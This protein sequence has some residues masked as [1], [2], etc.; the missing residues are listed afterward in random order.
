MNLRRPIIAL[1]LAIQAAHG[2]VLVNLD[3][4][5]L[6]AGA[7]TTWS[8]SGTLGGSFTRQIDTP[9]VTTVA[10]VKAVTLDGANDWYVGPTAPASVTGNGVRTVEVW[11]YNPA[12]ADEETMVA[13]GR[14]GGGDGTN[15]SFG[16]GSNATYGAVAH[17]G[18]PDVGWG[19]VP[20]AASW[21]Y[22]VY[23]FDGSVTRMYSDG[24]LRN[25]ES[26]ALNTW[27]VST[28]GA[29][30]PFVIGT[31][32]SADGTRT[33]GTY[34]GSMSIAKVRVRNE[35]LELPAIETAYISEGQP[36]GKGQ[37]LLKAFA[38]SATGAVPAGTPVQL[39]WNVVGATSVS[40]SNAPAI[41]GASGTVIVF[42][43]ATTTYTFTATNAAGITTQ[44]A[45]VTVG[46]FTP[47]AM[48]HRYSFNEASGTSVL[49]SV[50]TAHG[51]ILGAGW[52]RA[53]GSV[54]LPGGASG[55]APYVDLPNSLVSTLSNCT[56]EGWV[57]VTGNQAWSRI[58]DFGTGT[59]G[60]ITA[61]GSNATGT[62]YLFLSAQVGG[63]SNTQRAAL[64]ANNQGENFSDGAF[65]TVFGVETHFAVS[66]NATGNA[67]SPQIQYYRDG[68][69]VA[70][71]NTSYTLSQISDVNNWLGRSNYTADAN[72]QGA[73]NEFRIWNGAFNANDV[74]QSRNLGPSSAPVGPYI[75][76]FFA[77]PSTIYDGESTTLYWGVTNQQNPFSATITP[78][79]GSVSGTSGSTVVIPAGLGDVTYTFSG[80]NPLGTRTAQAVVTVL[81]GAP[82]AASLSANTFQE[83]AKA[84]TLTATDPNTPVGSL[85]YSYGQP[86]HGT[87]TGVAP[88]VTYTPTPGY[89]G[90]DSFTYTASDSTHTSN[91]ATVSI[92]VLSG[93][94]IANSAS[95]STAQNVA[96][97]ITLVAT[98]P[99]TPLGGLTYAY[100]QPANGTVTGSGPSVTYTPSSGFFGT[101]S[102]SFTAGDGTHVSTAATITITV[103]PPPTA[104]TFITPSES[105]ILTDI[106][107]GSFFARLQ[108]TDPNPGDTHTFSL[109]AGTGDTHNAFF[110]VVGNQ[111]ISSHSFAGDAGQTISIR[112]RATDNTG[113]TFDRVITFPVQAAAPHVK[114]NEIHYNPARNTLLSEFIELYNPTG[115]AVDMSGWRFNSGVNY[116][117]PPGTTIAAGGYLV[118][119]KDPA[120]I[121]SLYGVTA[122]GPWEG[123]LDSQGEEIILRDTFGNKIDGVDYGITSPWPTASNG[124]GPSLELVHPALDNDM[125]G[126]WRAS[127]RAPVSV[128]YVTA[129]S[130][131]WRYRKGTSEASSPVTAWRG[132]AF[133]EDGTW[134]TGTAPIGVFKQNNNTSLAT[135]AETGVT[136]GT[137]LTDMAAYSG[138]FTTSYRSVFFR[139]TFTA[140]SDIPKQLLLR[141][142]HN[143]AA[144]IWINSVEVARF[145][146][147]EGSPASPAFNSSAYY[148]RGNDPWSEK[149]IL[150]TDTLLHS[151]TNTIAIMGF[152]KPPQLRSEQEDVGA[153][154]LFD[155]CIDASLTNVPDT[156]GTPGA[157]NSVF[158]TNCPPAVRNITQVPKQLVS[159]APVTITAKVSDPQGVGSVTLSYQ[160]CTAGN[161]IPATLPLSIAALQADPNQPL[162]ANPAFENTAN[163]TTISM[164]DNG[165]VAGDVAGDGVFTAIIPAQPHRALVRYR[166]NATDLASQAV[167]L[168]AVG[169][170]RLNFAA[171]V[172]DGVPAYGAFTPATLNTL[173]AYHWITRS[174][175]FSSLL[176]YNGAEQIPNSN[177]L[178]QLL[179]RRYEN[180]EGTLV[181]GDQVID[182]ARIRLRG[183]NSRYAGVSGVSNIGKRHFRLNFPKGTPLQAEDNYGNKY[184][185][186]WEE[187]LFNKMF[188]NKGYHDF[189]LPYAV[190]GKMWDLTGVPTPGNHWVHFRVVQNANESDPT[191]GD[192]WGMYQALETPEGKNFLAARNLPNGNFYK[193][194]D[195]VQNGEM[196]DR[197]QAATSVDFAEDFDNIR[198]NIHQGTTQADME[199]FINM[200]AYYR[201][202]A[203]QEAIRH[204]D[205]FVE[206]TGRHRVKN[207][208]WWFEPQV[209]NPLGRC[210]FMPYDWDA[211][212]GPSWNSGYEMV[213]NA[214]Y[215]LYPITDS[216]TWTGVIQNRAAM[217]I[218]RRNAIRE[219][220]DLLVY[221]D[222]TGR[223]PVD[224]IIDD[225]YARIAAFW[226]ADRQR[227][228]ATGAQAD[229]PS[230]PPYKVAD[231]KSFLFTGWTDPVNADPAVGAGGRAAYLD[232]ISDGFDAGQLP[233]KPTIT[234]ASAL[235]HPVDGLAFTSSAFSDPQGAGTFAAMQWRVGEITD[236]LAPE[237][238]PAA[239][240]V[241]EIT[242]VWT[243]GELPTFNASVTIPGSALR[244]GH[245][246]RARVRH[247]DNTGRWSHWSNPVAFTCTSSNY[248]QVLKDNLVVSEFMY[249][250]DDPDLAEATAGYLAG[251]FEWIELRNVSTSLTLDLSN[252]RFTKGVDFDFQ[253][254]AITSLAPGASALVVKDAA[255]FSMRYGAGHPIAGEWDI[256]DNL[257][258]SGEQL[259]LSL[260]AGDA[261]HDFDYKPIAPWPTQANLGG[262][263]LVLRSP[264]TRPNHN[265]GG[266]WRASSR[267]DGTPGL[268]GTVFSE[269]AS[270]NLVAGETTDSDGDGIGNQLE[271]GLG[272]NPNTN[273]R[274][275]LPTASIQTLVVSGTPGNY[276]TLTFRR[277]PAAEDLTYSAE[278]SSDLSSP[279]NWAASGVF[280]SSTSNPDGSVS[281][282][283]RAATPLTPGQRQFGRVKMVKP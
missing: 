186:K 272:A 178:N 73:F 257:S 183:G 229:H 154:N 225:A 239:P 83:T 132:E 276:L 50:G 99:D 173:P 5:A 254:S 192:F 37:P 43:S 28:G 179:A 237:Y 11:A 113:R 137:Q 283:W 136:L 71:L 227:W 67:G 13:W 53:G 107:S 6:P 268:A 220:R 162:P 221:R 169:D 94:P 1:A 17:W 36:F 160:I 125:G 280:V 101:D 146:F 174:S 15:V 200:P 4:T 172:Y 64:K 62:G 135:L 247:K 23:V 8:N 56:V 35:A 157:Q 250:P 40:I 260:G 3:A 150:N 198:Y 80:T 245:T 25:T 49:D 109:V 118:I 47:P 182:H 55:T 119:A 111:L 207:L 140:T 218:Q 24:V 31:Q 138:G 249:R 86:A 271:Y 195:W 123:G 104:P 158:S 114:I 33:S 213:V 230:G 223:G 262:Y 256:E 126:H 246:Y 22:L 222:G 18:T 20:T 16:F 51:T 69:L 176:A 19:T 167:R 32:N 144:V 139:R 224:D 52:N 232:T 147:P 265:V 81:S 130:T 91:T 164:V 217:Q 184:P 42:P 45:T 128:N 68:A 66:Y 212:F 34:G 100:S 216:P 251:D 210:L 84:I 76:S 143:D 205:L 87:V 266:N 274:A 253:G 70:T 279:F 156:L 79:P 208:I 242:E 236:P 124:D 159:T 282:T 281:E 61:P 275:Q 30:L 240:R 75:N 206:P 142:M 2:E 127:T 57:T 211:S 273:S 105:T 38:S 258:N 93:A 90:P 48:T 149:V 153:Y 255:A 243:S 180:W 252:V 145:G 134:L 120:V 121:A 108:A 238:D 226:P 228:P 202:N 78:A 26:T 188:G 189:G 197:Y 122:L 248:L 267:F 168:P 163:W 177:A 269:W 39:S 219:L 259:K 46:A 152:A 12:L 191:L 233:A 201:Y 214:L 141:V 148:E 129:G 209:G 89:V 98:D 190:G 54:N 196:S 63:D 96:V 199:K 10:G 234:D 82:V 166:I 264:Q 165:T 235:N 194:S 117:F 115:A 72:M 27:A 106:A 151:G 278:F 193:M 181:V 203:V 102:F 7:L 215:N 85:T 133:V 170:P 277:M 60:E 263:S 110:S 9:S 14:R 112:V 241:Y 92:T 97:G 231:M 116:I 185:R 270:A 77:N 244:D 171:Y 204:Y 88:N 44:N 58:F 65:S 41:S 175:D 261:I 155:F 29:P 103:L 161:Y 74:A 187:M 131:G 21:H 95:A 59:A